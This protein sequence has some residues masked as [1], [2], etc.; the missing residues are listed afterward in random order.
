MIVHIPA[1]VS[2]WAGYIFGAASTGENGAEDVKK[3]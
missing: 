1:L 2:P 3:P